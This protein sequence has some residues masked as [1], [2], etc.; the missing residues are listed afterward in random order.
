[1]TGEPGIGESVSRIA[2]GSLPGE[3]KLSA[4]L[5]QPSSRPSGTAYWVA[6]LRLA[7]PP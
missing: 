7:R 6:L 5:T 1:M 4:L 2:A 3:P